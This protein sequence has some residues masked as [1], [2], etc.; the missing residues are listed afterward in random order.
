MLKDARDLS[1]IFK[2][3][4]GKVLIPIPFLLSKNFLRSGWPSEFLFLSR[5]F[6]EAAAILVT[7][8]VM[9]SKFW[10]WKAR[11]IN[12]ADAS[13]NSLLLL[14]TKKHSYLG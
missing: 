8:L 1:K 4:A 9:Q 7:Y 5:F 3:R 12:V 6:A 14:G 10:P 2:F 13:L 11:S